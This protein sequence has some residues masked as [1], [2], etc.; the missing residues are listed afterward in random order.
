MIRVKA[1]GIRK[2]GFIMMK[3]PNVNKAHRA[4]GQEFSINP[5]I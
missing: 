1:V 3:T 5:L 4:F 2:F